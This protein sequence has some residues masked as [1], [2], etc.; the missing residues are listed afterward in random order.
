MPELHVD[1]HPIEGAARAVGTGERVTGQVADALEPVLRAVV[2][3]VP[4]SRTSRAAGEASDA[5]PAAVRALAVELA[6]LAGALGIAA[7]RYVK[8][9]RDAT[10]GFERAGRRPA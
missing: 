3:A 9:E 7:A 6:A 1:P 8:A 2:A 10:E 4:G 5:L